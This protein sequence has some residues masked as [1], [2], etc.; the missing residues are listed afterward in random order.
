MIEKLSFD[1]LKCLFFLF[2]CLLTRLQLLTV[3]CIFI[4]FPNSPRRFSH[5]FFLQFRSG[6]N[7]WPKGYL[8]SFKIRF[9]TIL[10]QNEGVENEWCMFCIVVNELNDIWKCQIT[11]DTLLI[12]NMKVEVLSSLAIDL[13]VPFIQERMLSINFFF[14]TSIRNKVQT[15]IHVRNETLFYD[16]CQKKKKE[17][18]QKAIIS[19]RTMWHVAEFRLLS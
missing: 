14:A 4:Q 5:F 15:H 10:H 16:F 12:I 2:S 8:R 18:E 1:F 9:N 3:H 11:L 7:N 19:C 17:E 6:L 13:S